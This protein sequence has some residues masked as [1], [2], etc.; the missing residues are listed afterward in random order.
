MGLPGKTNQNKPF[1]INN[2]SNS[3]GQVLPPTLVLEPHLHLTVEVREQGPQQPSWHIFSHRWIE[4]GTTRVRIIPISAD[5]MNG[6][7]RDV[8]TAG[9][10]GQ[11]SVACLPTGGDGISTVFTF[12]VAQLQEFSQRR[13][14]TG[15]GLYQAWGEWARLT[16]ARVALLLAL[17][18]STL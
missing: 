11:G 13:L 1:L 9:T 15:T 17:V 16:G 18:D 14:T 8:L 3:A 7:S 5:S 6:A 2:Q 12:G 4:S 10:T